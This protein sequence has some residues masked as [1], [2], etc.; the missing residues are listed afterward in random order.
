MRAT[1]VNFAN[2]LVERLA[3]WERHIKDGETEE[4]IE[5]EI[6][7]NPLGDRVGFKFYVDVF[8]T[9]GERKKVGGIGE[10]SAR[11][12]DGTFKESNI[13]VNKPDD[14][15]LVEIARKQLFEAIE[16]YDDAQ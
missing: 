11:I 2:Y 12:E 7:V 10:V 15:E 4:V 6:R 9:T 8:R 1:Q 14:W 13:L 16:A 5:R 3:D